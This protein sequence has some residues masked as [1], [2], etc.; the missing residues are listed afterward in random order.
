MGAGF[1]SVDLIIET[2]QDGL[3][4]LSPG[5]VHGVLWLQTHF[6][7]AEWD[8]LF[9]SRAVFETECLQSLLG[10]AQSAGVTVQQPSVVES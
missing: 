6:P 7:P 5:S 10:D 3:H 4:R 2:Q 9:E 1:V 8:V